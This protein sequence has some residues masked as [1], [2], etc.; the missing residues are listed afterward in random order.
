MARCMTAADSKQ[1]RSRRQ[2]ARGAAA[3]DGNQCPVARGTTANAGENGVKGA[4][5]HDF[6]GGRG[7]TAVI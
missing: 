1:L 4:A 5:Q 3:A 6:K 7:G 2:K